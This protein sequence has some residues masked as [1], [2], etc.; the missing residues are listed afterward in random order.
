MLPQGLSPILLFPSEWS[1]C[2]G[3]LGDPGDTGLGAEEKFQH[4]MF[5]SLTENLGGNSLLAWASAAQADTQ[6]LL[7]L[8]NKKESGPQ[9]EVGARG[10]GGGQ[11]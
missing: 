5:C 7:Y 1:P 8:K 2:L 3:R 10:G 9:S 6:K 11:S 4:E